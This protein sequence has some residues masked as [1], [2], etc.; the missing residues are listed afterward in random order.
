MSESKRKPERD[1]ELG[2][3]F[4]PMPAS[5]SA[6][7]DEALADVRAG[8]VRRRVRPGLVAAYVC[9]ASF[10]ALFAAALLVPALR[11]APQPEDGRAVCELCPET[12]AQVDVYAAIRAAV[13]T[14][15]EFG[16][17]ASR[18]TV[19]RMEIRRKGS[20]YAVQAEVRLYAGD[21]GEPYDVRMVEAAVEQAD[22]CFR[23]TQQRDLGA[24]PTVTPEPSPRTPAPT[25]DAAA[26]PRQSTPTPGDAQAADGVQPD[27]A[28][29]DG[30]Q[31]EDALM[32]LDALAADALRRYDAARR[33]EAASGGLEA[34]HQTEDT[35]LFLQEIELLEALAGRGA[36]LPGLIEPDERPAAVTRERTETAAYGYVRATYRY[37]R[38]ESGARGRTE[39]TFTITFDPQAMAIVG[40]EPGQAG[41]LRALL[42][43]LAGEQLAAGFT[44][45]EANAYAAEELA[46]QLAHGTTVVYAG[47]KAALLLPAAAD[48]PACALTALPDGVPETAPDGCAAIT[49]EQFA[50]LSALAVGGALPPDGFALYRVEADGR[51]TE[52][53][54]GTAEALAARMAHEGAAEY[55][56]AFRFLPDAAAADG[57][58]DGPVPV[59]A[60]PQPAPAGGAQELLLAVRVR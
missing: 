1:P 42:D 41:P 6:R 33:G 58:A 47:G 54:C 31:Q 8:R 10:A 7:V 25:Q 22:G 35:A 14:Q 15:L 45:E 28:Q 36:R 50:C 29:Q 30:M 5:F 52:L 16:A 49:R 23:V 56:V 24:W 18:Y 57:A 20:G 37:T 48:E 12:T 44:R 9:A 53:L 32:Q 4:P 3:L 19:G 27:G 43:A 40:V 17:Q 2:G 39:E 34:V 59:G 21:A 60:T 11:G 13:Q 38:L 51:L 26:T 46:A 55:L